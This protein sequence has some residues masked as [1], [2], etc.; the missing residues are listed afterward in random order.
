MVIEALLRAHEGAAYAYDRLLE[1]MG[2]ADA[3]PSRI[4]R[5]KHFVSIEFIRW[6][7]SKDGFAR[8]GYRNYRGLMAGSFA[9]SP[10][11]YRHL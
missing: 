6:F 4:E 3:V 11:P 2:V 8:F 5:V 7:M 1:P 9:M 10:P